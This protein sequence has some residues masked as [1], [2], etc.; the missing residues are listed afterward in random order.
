MFSFYVIEQIRRGRKGE[1][2]TYEEGHRE[3][4]MKEWPDEKCQK[5]GM[6]EGGSR[7]RKGK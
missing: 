7:D 4:D 5:E 6:R 1:K 2:E 3:T